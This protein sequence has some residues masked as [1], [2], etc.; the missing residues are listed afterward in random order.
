[1]LEITTYLKALATNPLLTFIVGVGTG[2]AG[3]YLAD[4]YT[5][6]RRAKELNAALRQ[7]FQDAASMMPELIKEMQEDLSKPEYRVV[8]EFVILP[9]KHVSFSSS[10]KK[11]I[12]Y[13]ED[14][15]QELMNKVKLLENCGFIYNATETRT[16]K[17]GM[18]EEFVNCLLRASIKRNKIKI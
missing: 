2:A 9:N 7:M 13:F 1:V 5:D 3:K 15:H 16:P 14:E 18:T 12:C 6:R 10:G 11:C 17:Y 4:K 8:R